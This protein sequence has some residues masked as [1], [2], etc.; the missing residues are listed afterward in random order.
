GGIFE[1]TELALIRA[2]FAGS[3]WVIVTA[4]QAK[5]GAPENQPRS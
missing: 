1:A 5:N 2:L 4:K 3:R